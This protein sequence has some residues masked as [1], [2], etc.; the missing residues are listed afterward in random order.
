MYQKLNCNDK[1]DYFK[2]LSK[3]EREGV[4]FCRFI[5]FDEELLIWER[6]IQIDCQK[7]GKYISKKLPQPNENEVFHFFDKV[8]Q[9]DFV[10]EQNL[11]YEI[12]VKWLDF[13]PQKIQKNI[14]EAI[15]YI[16]YELSTKQNNINI[17]KNTFVKFMCWLKYYFG[18]MLCTLG[19]EEVPKILYE[20]DISKYELYLLRVLCFSGCD[21][22]YVH[23]YDEASYFKIDT[24]AMWSNVIYGKRRGQPPKHF[25]NIDLNV[26][27]KQQQTDKNIQSVSDFVKTNILQKEDFWQNLFQTNSQRALLD[28]NHYYNIFIQ[29]IGVDQLEIY[30]NRLYTLKQ[31]LKQKAKPFL[32]VEQNIENPSIEESNTLR[33]TKY[34]NQKD[35]LQQFSEKIVLL[36]NTILQRLFQRAFFTIMEQYTEQSISKIYNTALKLVCW[37]NRYSSILFQNF[38][39][40]QIPLFLYYGKINKNQALFLNMLSYL[41]VDVLYISPKKEYHTVFEEIENNSIVIE[42]ENDSEMFCFPQKAIRVKQATTAYQAERELDSILYEDTGLY[43]PKQFIHSQT[44]TL[45]TIYEEISIIWKEEAKYR[46]GFEIKENIV[47]IP[48]IFAKINGVKEGD[49]SK[50]LKSISELLT[51]NTIFIKN[52]PYIARVGHSPSFAAQ[53]LNKNKIDIKAVKKHSNYRYD[54]LN[55]QTQNYILQKAQEMLDLKWI[56]A[57]GVDIEKV[58]LYIILNLDKITLQMIQQ[59]DFTKEI[60]KVVVVSVNENIATLED[61]I[62]LLYLNLIGF[63]IVVFTPTGYR[64]IDKY[65]SKKAF[66]EYE[67]GEYLFQMEIPERAKL[68]R[69]AITTESGLFNRIFGRRK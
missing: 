51:E 12:I 54:F 1:Q 11:F 53:F 44:V 3:R 8:G 32:I 62:Y 20:G 33:L 55:L 9:F 69:M 29:Y 30:Q 14:S 65:I 48:N 41:P 10:I 17:L 45:K 28:R 21:V 31:E 22:V 5:G 24:A 38:D 6:K 47:T 68:E 64:N 23:F 18:N 16:L 63:D 7:N 13:V 66:E 61:A 34:E 39:Y 50:Y 25:K 43:R 27:E 59:F 67:I 15:Y 56:E 49:I 57:E 58:I 40:E 26:L 37:L 52:F 35:M 36:G 46:P 2:P 4:Y 42:L 60:P 19:E